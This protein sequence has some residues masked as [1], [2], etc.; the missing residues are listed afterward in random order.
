M[1]VYQ[2]G[3]E[4]SWRGPS[5]SM[6]NCG[7]ALPDPRSGRARCILVVWRRNAI[8]LSAT[9][10]ARARP[11]GLAPFSLNIGPEHHLTHTAAHYRQWDVSD[12]L[13]KRRNRKSQDSRCQYSRQDKGPLRCLLHCSHSFATH[14]PQT[15]TLDSRTS[16]TLEVRRCG[17]FLKRERRPGTVFAWYMILYSIGRFS[18]EVLQADSRDS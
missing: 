3:V 8:R 18:L 7:M 9:Y 14:F 16:T 10:G 12:L 2:K 15:S 5:R 6:E 4:K 17:L 11:F 1:R 13:G